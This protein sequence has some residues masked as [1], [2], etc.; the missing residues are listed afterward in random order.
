MTATKKDPVLVVLPAFRW[1]R[2]DEYRRAH[3]DPLYYDNRPPCACPRGR[4][5][6]STDTSA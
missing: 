4:P 6:T 2:R 3:G 5:W 1:Q